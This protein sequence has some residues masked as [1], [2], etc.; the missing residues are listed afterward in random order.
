MPHY[1]LA[2]VDGTGSAE[3]RRPDGSNSH[4]FRFH[5]DLRVPA[6]DKRY[7]E[8]PDSLG[9]RVGSI[10]DS[11]LA[12]ILRR[13]GRDAGTLL[14]R[15]DDLPADT[16]ICLVG[17][18]RGGLIVIEVARSLYRHRLPVW[19]L[20]LY[21]A[22]DMAIGMDG[23]RI[24]NVRTTYHALRSRALGSRSSWGNT[25]QVSTGRYLEKVFETSHG[26]IGGD[27]VLRPEGLAADYSCSTTGL[28]A[29]VMR[30]L[31]TDIG[32]M[33]TENSAEADRWIRAWA[34]SQQLPI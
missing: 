13:L 34:R 14:C 11:V 27:P 4:C 15:P 9:T 33:C 30:A 7:F 16:R 25:G 10:H 26:G 1:L 18:S 17:H 6:A 29:D 3:W 19:F 20:G 24:D 32:Q 12:W 8:G 28:R 21:D 5:R 23:S 2:A 22:V 31:G